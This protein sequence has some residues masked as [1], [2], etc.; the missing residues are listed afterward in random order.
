MAKYQA[1]LAVQIGYKTLRRGYTFEA[2]DNASNEELMKTAT[3]FC[4]G[5]V[6]SEKSIKMP[7]GVHEVY[8]SADNLC[9]ISVFDVQKVK[10]I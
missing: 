9:V 10:E 8:I 2:A 4:K 3:E 1:R 6:K 7:D 5:F